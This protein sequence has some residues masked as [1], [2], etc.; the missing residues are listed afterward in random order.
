LAGAVA[1]AAEAAAQKEAMA[2]AAAER[3]AAPLLGVAQVSLYK[4]FFYLESYVLNRY[5]R[6]PVTRPHDYE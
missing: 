6:I 2:M 4:R 3:V 1:A 5:S